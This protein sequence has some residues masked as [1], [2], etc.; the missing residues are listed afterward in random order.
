M[1]LGCIVFPNGYFLSFRMIREWLFVHKWGVLC[2]M[3]TSVCTSSGLYH[4]FGFLVFSPFLQNILEWIKLIALTFGWLCL[5][6]LVRFL[7]CLCVCLRNYFYLFHGLIIYTRNHLFFERMHHLLH[8]FLFG[9]SYR[10]LIVVQMFYIILLL[11]FL[12]KGSSFKGICLVL[13][14]IS[15]YYL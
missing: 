13:T 2:I 14:V 12:I 6:C 1:W 9:M 15:L 3:L 11:N 10:F 4:T 5:V 7:S 8:L